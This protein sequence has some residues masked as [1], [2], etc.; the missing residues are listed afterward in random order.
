MKRAILSLLTIF[1]LFPIFFTETYAQEAEA[2]SE[3]PTE[4]EKQKKPSKKVKR[5]LR[6]FFTEGDVTQARLIPI[7]DED[8]YWRLSFYGFIKGNYILSSHSVLSY[9]RENLVAPNM[10][11]RRV[12]FDDSQQRSNI[13]VNETRIGFKS[14]L[15]DKLKGYIEMDFIDFQKSNANVNV[16]PRLRQA[17]FTYSYNDHLDIFIGQRWD[18]FSPLNPDTYNIIN[19]LFQ[20]GNVGWMREQ[21]GFNFYQNSKLSFSGAL[22]NTAVNTSAGPSIRLEH[23]KAPTAALQLKYT[24]IDHLTLYLS[25]L[26]VSLNQ[27]DPATTT[28]T[29]ANGSPRPLVY[30]GSLES[31]PYIAGR[32]GQSNR[33]RRQ[34]SGISLGSEYKTPKLT[35][36]WEGNWGSNLANLNTLGIGSAQSITTNEKFMA[37]KYGIFTSSDPNHLL[38]PSNLYGLSKYN[39]R[40]V[41][42]IEE[43]GAWFSFTYKV[44][45]KWDVGM[46]AGG[47]KI[48]NSKDLRPAINNNALQDFSLAQQDPENGRWGANQLGPVIENTNIGYNFAYRPYS[49]MRIFF[50]HERLQTFYHNP[51][52]EKGVLAHI[53]SIDVSTMDIKLKENL[54]AP[55]YHR[56]SGR[57]YTHL[58]RIGAMFTF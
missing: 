56:A 37:S 17:T 16:N 26:T 23:N 54:L 21:I 27:Y 44:T 29:L 50:Q 4:E 18:I 35:F 51:E 3:K 10:A 45:D 8:E 14:E 7:T 1:S 47:V 12:Q 55:S 19:S 31:V 48:R 57:A 33:I 22:G 38:N 28:N 41:I 34:A 2:E 25:T 46:L 39:R 58:F 30:D 43:F 20:T 53:Q 52:R 49:G 11:K 5:K 6:I 9:G 32:I 13:S 24:P 15:G 40:E 42:S 36:K